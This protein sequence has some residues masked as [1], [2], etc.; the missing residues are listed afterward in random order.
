MW[1]IATTIMTEKAP[2][3][4]QSNI[5]RLTKHG[6]YKAMLLKANESFMPESNDRI[7]FGGMNRGI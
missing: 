2:Q 6:S 5:Q 3:T 4:R 1:S 7:N